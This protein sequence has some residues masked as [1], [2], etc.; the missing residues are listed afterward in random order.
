MQIN[1]DSYCVYIHTFPNGKVYVGITCT[2]PERRWRADGSGYRKQE[3]ITQPQR[4]YCALKQERFFP[5]QLVPQKQ[6]ML[7]EGQFVLVYLGVQ[8]LRVVITGSMR[9]NL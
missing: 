9:V 7:V 8:K 5:R 6:L 1:N 2:A 3:Q 4:V